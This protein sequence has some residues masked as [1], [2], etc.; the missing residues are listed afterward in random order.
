ME[1][2]SGATIHFD[3]ESNFARLVL[4]S[5]LGSIPGGQSPPTLLLFLLKKMKVNQLET[6]NNSPPGENFLK[7]RW[8]E[9]RERKRQGT[10]QRNLEDS[11][12]KKRDARSKSTIET[13]QFRSKCQV[14]MPDLLFSTVCVPYAWALAACLSASA[15]GV[16][17]VS[18]ELYHAMMSPKLSSM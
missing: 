4:L 14:M 8:L 9:S 12:L 3:M 1:P 16:P 6:W 18:S 11:G 17:Q 2:Y 10:R 13:K 5:W 7:R 15:R